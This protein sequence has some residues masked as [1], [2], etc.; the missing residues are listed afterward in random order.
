MSEM[1]RVLQTGQNQITQHYGNGHNGVD[2]VKLSGQ[3]DN[4]IAHSDGKVIWCQT[5]MSNNPNA[6]E[7][8]NESYGNCVK[9]KHDNGMYTLYAHM[10]NV[11][12]GINQRVAKGQV[13]GTMSN[14]GRAYGSH[15]HFEVFNQNNS[16]VNPEP[17][18]N[19]DLDGSVECT[20]TI[21]YQAY[22]GKWEDEVK[23]AD[24]TPNGYAGDSVHFISGV[25]AKPQYGELIIEAHELGGQWLG[26]ISSKSYKTNDMQDDNSYAGIYG[27]PMDKYRIKS[28][29]G[30]VDYRV[31]VKVNNK[32]VWLDW[33]RGFG[34]KPSEYAGIEGLP[35]Y[36]IQMI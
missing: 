32:L 17:Y 36:G 29:K 23:K 24:N 9:I 22:D 25:R 28:T 19:K 20:G 2:L 21:I 35:I 4:I 27:K 33:V 31:L 3:I 18:L 14:S 34:D 16:R 12:V 5:G 7:W 30:W 1:S 26:A 10:T 11:R 8:S 6:P 15:L 13:I